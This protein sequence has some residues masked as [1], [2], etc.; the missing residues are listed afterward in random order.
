MLCIKYD[1]HGGRKVK[2]HEEHCRVPTYYTTEGFANPK[3]GFWMWVTHREIAVA[4]ASN[5]NATFSDAKCCH[6]PG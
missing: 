4:L 2:L 5:L 6:R 1:K 3:R